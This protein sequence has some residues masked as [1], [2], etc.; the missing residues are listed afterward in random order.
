MVRIWIL[1]SML[2]VTSGWILSALGRL[3]G[4]GYG[5]LLP[6]GVAACGYFWRK[7][8]GRPPANP[9]R[10]LPRFR[11][12][13]VRM[14]PL[15]FLLL[16]AL[17]LLG[18]VWYPPSNGSST[19]Y[20]IPRVMHWLAAGHWHWIRTMDPR[21]N[22][23]GCGYEWFLAPILLLSHTD[24][25]LFLPN[26]ISFLLMPG[27]IF[28]VFTRLG[29]RPRVAW[30]WMWLLPTGWCFVMQAG[31]TLNDTFASV[32]ALAA[33]D[34]ALRCR[35]SK[36]VGDL[37]FA[38]LAAALAT[39]VKQTDIPLAAP[40]LLAAAASIRLLFNR[41]LSSLA[42]IG[43]CLLTSALPMMILDAKYAG[44]WSGVTAHTWNG[45]VPPSPFW[46]VIGNVF[47]LTIQ[48]L[49]PP[50]FPFVQS[51][52]AARHHFLQT[53]FGRHFAG[54]EDF[55]RLSSGAAEST[56]ALG[57]GICLLIFISILAAR[58]YRPKPG[59][60]DAS[61][62]RDP[63]LRLLRWIPW[64]LLLVF[65]A[66]VGTIETG[67]LCGSYYF[68]LCPSLLMGAGLSILAR[69][70]WWQALA[71]LVM[72]LA[73]ALV[74]VSRDR[75]LFPSQTVLGRLAAEHPHSKLIAN[76]SLT[77]A[78]TPALDAERLFFR[79]NLPPDA[80]VLGYGAVSREC[81]SY[82]WL[83]YGQRRVEVVLP[84]DTLQQL[85][86]A[87][88]QY[89]VITQEKFLGRANLTIEQWLAQHQAVLIYQK[90]F[91]EDPYAPP[92]RYYL[93]RLPGP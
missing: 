36:S 73:V 1:L 68:L 4:F 62:R 24:R 37:W 63:L 67:R 70:R 92:E 76:L 47:Y 22:I 15:I 20:R 45:A 55:G 34:F 58:L 13:W 14:A 48:N 60:V 69:R 5:L 46:G 49:K 17:T 56:A 27:L 39:G 25:L 75:P 12:R 3:N 44:N 90:E 41:P 61:H 52:D 18:G 66:K 89:A 51:W 6:L 86:A 50:L 38:L 74:V 71:L 43:I 88:I 23:A 85:R 81:E 79:T 8:A 64:V 28:S 31:S 30:W 7:G 82:L 32:Y 35:V 84:G 26:W 72:A 40:G 53:P 21:I 87:G 29:V 83:P 80:A 42:V 10:W 93:A 57:L 65:M 9:S 2:M 91:L 19:A 16:A 11:R 78:A 54:F 77:Y 59:R 33:L